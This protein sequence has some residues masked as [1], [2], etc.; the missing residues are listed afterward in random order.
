MLKDIN[1]VYSKTDGEILKEFGEI[2]KQR[3]ISDNLTQQELAD[4]VGISVNHLSKIERTG[5]TTLTTLI[6]VSRQLRLLQELMDVYNLPE[7]MNV[8]CKRVKS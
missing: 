7:N 1:P 5:K 4:A 8:G 2:L 6:A 3:R